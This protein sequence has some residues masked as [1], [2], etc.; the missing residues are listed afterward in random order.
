LTV[1]HTHSAGTSYLFLGARVGPAVEEGPRHRPQGWY[2]ERRETERKERK[3][4]ECAH[5]YMLRPGISTQ[6]ARLPVTLDQWIYQ[7]S[8][9]LPRQQAV[10]LAPGAPGL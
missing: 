3:R 10:L 6:N 8:L 1:P 2:P 9:S 4:R 7:V 5:S